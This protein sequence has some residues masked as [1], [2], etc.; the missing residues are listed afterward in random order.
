MI[1]TTFELRIEKM[2]EQDVFIFQ[3][4]LHF[5]A[6]QNKKVKVVIGLNSSI[7]S[8]CFDQA[9]QPHHQKAIKSMVLLI[10][11]DSY[12]LLIPLVCRSFNFVREIEL[13]LNNFAL[14]FDNL[15]RR[16]EVRA[17]EKLVIR[18][19]KFLF[20][21]LVTMAENLVE[22]TLYFKELTQELQDLT[23]LKKLRVIEF[24]CVS[25]SSKYFKFERQ[26]F[27]IMFAEPS[28]V[29]LRVKMEAFN[30]E[31]RDIFK[32]FNYLNYPVHTV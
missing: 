3:T 12:D 32:K 7:N 2:Q 10:Q 22:M 29:Q 25:D 18:K 9:I 27:N 26:H 23:P 17:V 16:E 24:V 21:P 4:V 6:L 1:A 19:N 20:Y 5:I 15:P 30:I 14:N 11:K 28:A 13:N 31:L 8:Q